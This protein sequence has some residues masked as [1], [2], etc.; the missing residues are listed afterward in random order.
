MNTLTK[1]ALVAVSLAA[2]PVLAIAQNMPMQHDNMP[3]GQGNMG[4]GN[5]GQ[6]GMMM[7][8][9]AHG[10][11]NAGPSTKAFEDANAKMHKD[12]AITFSG[13]ADVDFARG[14]IPHHQGAIDMAKIELQYGKDPELKKLAEDIIKAQESEIAFLKAW[15]EK[16]AK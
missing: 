6:G 12:M 3:M 16:N 8:H 10:G 2:L 5:M 9:S 4:Q 13:N 11:G 7:D 14:M 15:L 1:A